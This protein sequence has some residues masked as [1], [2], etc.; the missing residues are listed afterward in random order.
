[1]NINNAFP[2]KWLK[3]GDIGDD[4]MVLT[5][6]A[7]EIEEVGQGD[8]AEHKPVVYFNETE[9]GMVLNK[10]NADAISKLHGPETDG[11]V[12]KAI[13]LFATEVDFAGKQTLALRVRLKAPKVAAVKPATAAQNG[14]GHKAA[15]ATF[16][17][18]ATY[19]GPFGITADAIKAEFNKRGFTGWK[20]ERSNVVYEMVEAAMKPAEVE[21]P[22]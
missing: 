13:A 5:I 3:S 22:F 2:S 14:N 8:D 7:V 21:E 15:F 20:P 11:W 6:R 10:T 19:A 4:D 17:E 1:M 18:A 16:Q 12:G 9:K